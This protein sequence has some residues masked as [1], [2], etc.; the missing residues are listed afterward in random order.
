MAEYIEKTALL[1][2]MGRRLRNMEL[3][4]PSAPDPVY[5]EG[6]RKGFELAMN[7]VSACEPADVRENV[8]PATNADRIRAMADEE[9]AEWI[10]SHI[11]ECSRCEGRN[12]NG[13]E[14]SFRDGRPY[15]LIDWLKSP[16]EG[17]DG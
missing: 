1:A 13:I 4:T 8:P 15:G 10:C 2:D 3:R 17:G 5:A 9:L 16:V 12:V 14:C 11:T 7:W 6:V